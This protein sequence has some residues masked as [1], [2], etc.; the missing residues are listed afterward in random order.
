MRRLVCFLG[1]HDV[2]ENERKKG[3]ADSGQGV[4]AHGEDH[5]RFAFGYFL[6]GLQ[7]NESNLKREAA[8]QA[9]FFAH[10]NMSC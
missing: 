8:V 6:P 3:Q 1:Q 4:Y 7:V 9:Y 2:N 10:I 5:S